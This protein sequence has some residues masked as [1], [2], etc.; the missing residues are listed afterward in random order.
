MRPLLLSLGLLLLAGGIFQA[1]KRFIRSWFKPGVA[2]QVKARPAEGAAIPLRP[3]R[4]VLIDGLGEREADTIPALASICGDGVRLRVDVGFPSVSL[5]VQ[6]VLWTGAWQT[7]SGIEFAVDRLRHPAFET[8]PE[9]VAR[10][11]GTSVAVAESHPE[12]ASSFPFSRVVVMPRRRSERALEQNVLAAAQA[13]D[14]LV[15]V[16]LLAVDESGHRHGSLSPQYRAAARGAGQVV[17]ALWRVRR[18][19][20]TVLVLSDHGHLPRGGHGDLEDEVRWVR[21]CLAGPGIPSGISAR[22]TMPDLNAVLAERLGVT[23][24]AASAGRS[25]AS[26]LAGGP[27]PEQPRVGC[28][29]VPFGLLLGLL[30]VLLAV[31]QG[32]RQ[33]EHRG[34]ILFLAFPFAPALGV[35]LVTLGHGAPSLSRAYVYPAT[36]S[37]LIGPALAAALLAGLQHWA[38]LRLGLSRIRSACLLATLAVTPAVAC[39]AATGYPL[40]KPPLCP[41][42]TAWASTL[43]LVVAVVL[44]ALGASNLVLARGARG[45]SVSGVPSGPP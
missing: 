18:P 5:P 44:A 2:I 40:S 42:V 38:L 32:R 36:P 4:V 10:R 39:L 45:L 8:L 20:W 23:A 17:A 37:S 15:F 43:L 26:L 12:V 21:A 28:P 22:A 33:R 25:L 27:T 34:T 6:H 19:D 3:V 29:A 7:Q 16:H 30:F 13:P 14:A 35:L 9:V 11:S 41:Y 24:P 31:A 1:R